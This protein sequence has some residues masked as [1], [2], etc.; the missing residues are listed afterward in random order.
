MAP[1]NDDILHIGQPRFLEIRRNIC[2]FLVPLS[3]QA[4]CVW[5]I[6]PARLKCTERINQ[7]RNLLLPAKKLVKSEMQMSME[8]K[9]SAANVDNLTADLPN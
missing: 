1:I 5:I 2:N 8:E 6:V 9:G 7:R 4:A 3:W